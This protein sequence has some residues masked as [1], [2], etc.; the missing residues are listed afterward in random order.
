MLGTTGTVDERLDLRRVV[1]GLERGQSLDEQFPILSIAIYIYYFRT[2]T[3]YFYILSRSLQ[4]FRVVA[5]PLFERIFRDEVAHDGAPMANLWP[6]PSGGV[7]MPPDG[8]GHRFSIRVWRKHWPHSIPVSNATVVSTYL[9]VG[10]HRN[11]N[12]QIAP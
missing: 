11:H 9:L 10:S 7:Y 2:S 5:I 4:E 6:V 3:V 8:M 1:L 12:H